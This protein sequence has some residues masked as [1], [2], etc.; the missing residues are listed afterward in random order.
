MI[1][2]I[3]GDGS[4]Q[5]RKG[6]FQSIR[7]IIHGNWHKFYSEYSRRI[8]ENFNL[9]LTV[10]INKR[11]NTSILICG[12]SN[13]NILRNHIIINNLPIVNRKWKQE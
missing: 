6:K 2:F 13:F 4:I 3:D 9:K 10:N 7:I 8:E 11:G 5:F 12:I 1:G